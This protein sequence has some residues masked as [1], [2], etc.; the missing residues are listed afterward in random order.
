MPFW[1]ILIYFDLFWSILLLQIF[2]DVF[3]HVFPPVG[4]LTANEGHKKAY[5]LRSPWRQGKVWELLQDKHNLDVFHE[6][7]MDPWFLKNVDKILRQEYLIQNLLASD[8][9][10]P[11]YEPFINGVKTLTNGLTNGWGPPCMSSWSCIIKDARNPFSSHSQ[12][13]FLKSTKNK[14]PRKQVI[15]DSF[16]KSVSFEY[17]SKWLPYTQDQ[18]VFAHREFMKKINYVWFPPD[19]PCICNIY[20]YIIYKF[21]VFICIYIYIY[22]VHISIYTFW[23]HNFNDKRQSFTA[24]SSD[25]CPNVKD[26]VRKAKKP[27]SVVRLVPFVKI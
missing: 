24:R 20:I 12:K 18:W 17:G 13:M 3:F 21:I 26:R 6:S 23:H 2:R 25:C 22:V 9:S 7:V 10:Y 8:Q 14:P 5:A 4:A 1:S 27:R 11:I 19:S 16:L 15:P